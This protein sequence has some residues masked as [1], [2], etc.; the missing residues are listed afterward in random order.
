[1]ALD[2]SNWNMN[3][4]VPQS[5]IDMIKKM[6]MKGALASVAGANAAGGNGDTTATAFVE[7][8]RRLYGDQRYQNAMYKAQAS[9][10]PI[11]TM[12]PSKKSAKMPTSAIRNKLR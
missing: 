3:V 7:G 11:G 4:K 2:K 10:G 12:A 8:V 9:P 6:G 1:M 5:T